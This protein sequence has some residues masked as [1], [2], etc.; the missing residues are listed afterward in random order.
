MKGDIEMDETYCGGKESN[1]HES[2]KTEGSQG[3]NNKMAVFGII[4]R[5]GGVILEYIKK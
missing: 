4:K 3:G 2:R 1:K 5:K